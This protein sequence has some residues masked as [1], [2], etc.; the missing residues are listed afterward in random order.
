[1]MRFTKYGLLTVL[2]LGMT[3]VTARAQDVSKSVVSGGYQYQHMSLPSP[4]DAPNCSH[5]FG[6]GWY[7][8]FGYGVHP[9]I[10]IVGQVDGSHGGDAFGITGLTVNNVNYG[11][12]VRYTRKF[13]QLNRVTPFGQF[14]LGGSHISVSGDGGGTCNKCDAF[15][16][17]LDG[18]V[19]IP[20][21]G[22]FSA[23]LAAGYRRAFFSTDS[24]IGGGMN[25]FRFIAG[26]A[27]S[28]Q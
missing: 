10:S 16:L 26:I 24:D 22:M 21:S 1:M 12:G 7:V 13:Q 19:M 9:N 4:C 8:D 3:V 23:Q 25:I 11:G 28:I 18:G 15:A 20:V 2:A 6:G 14:I 5:G 27:Y 17:D